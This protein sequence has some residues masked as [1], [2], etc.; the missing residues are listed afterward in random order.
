M[1]FSVVL[2]EEERRMERM[3]TEASDQG[4]HR[5]SKNA[6]LHKGLGLLGITPRF[7]NA[8]YH[9]RSKSR[10]LSV[11]LTLA[12]RVSRPLRVAER[13]FDLILALS[14]VKDGGGR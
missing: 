6:N 13:E 7:S 2:S 12:M 3:A 9:I 11:Q 4:E 10:T 1:Q 14:W 8:Y 5:F